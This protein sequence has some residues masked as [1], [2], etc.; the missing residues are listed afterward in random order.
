MRAGGEV[1]SPHHLPTLLACKRKPGVG[2]FFTH[3]LSSTTSPSSL[4]NVSRGWGFPYQPATTTTPTLRSS[5]TRAERG[6]LYQPA[7]TT[8]PTLT[9]R[10]VSHRNT[11]T[12]CTRVSLFFF[13]FLSPPK[14]AY[15]PSYACFFSFSF[16]LHHQDM[17]T[18]NR[19]HVLFI[20]FSYE[21]RV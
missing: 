19:T 5:Q 16:C 9:P 1:F 4:A 7:T 20:Y 15:E 17:R 2:F 14:H 8:T 21:T 3:Q 13:C 18:S 6:F 12:K 11:R 10:L